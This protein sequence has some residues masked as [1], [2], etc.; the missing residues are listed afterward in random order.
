[1]NWTEEQCNKSKLRRVLP[2]KRGTR[3]SRPGVRGAGP[4]GP[5]RGDQE[6][7]KFKPNLNIREAEKREIIARVIEIAVQVMFSTH[8]Y[9]FGGDYYRQTTG[10][11]IGLRSTCS[12]A[13]LV[14]KVW[15]DKWLQRLQE[16]K[17][18]IEEAIRYMD[19]GRTALFRFKHGWRW[20]MGKIM[21]CKRWETED[22]HLSGIEITKRI[23]AGTM[24]GLEE[25]LEFTMETEEDFEDKWLPTLDT[26]L[27]V[28][29]DNIIMYQFYEKPTN[30]NTVL[31][32]RTAMAEDSKVRSLTNEVMKTSNNWRDDS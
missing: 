7:W 1:M 19:D 31:H 16:L 11:P 3:G 5:T 26:K 18:Q 29:K 24:A 6:Q 15:D 8:V 23:L 32:Q 10:G 22:Q 20:A 2:T 28:S 9:T 13:R 4:S 30:P 14:M 25:Y 27:C 21:Y 12:V 17:V